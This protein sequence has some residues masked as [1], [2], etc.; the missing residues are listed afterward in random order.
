M[1]LL[2]PSGGAQARASTKPSPP[3]RMPVP[4]LYVRD[5]WRFRDVELNCQEGED[6]SHA[7]SVRPDLR[8][9][10]CPGMSLAC[11]STYTLLM[12]LL[13]QLLIGTSM[14]R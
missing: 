14:R 3:N 1:C 6:I 5:M 8:R 9:V 13:M 4:K 2:L 7:A 10:V 11:V 12:P